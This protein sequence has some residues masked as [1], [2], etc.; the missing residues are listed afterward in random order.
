M[1][2]R[3][4]SPGPVLL[5]AASLPALLAVLA[6]CESMPSPGEELRAQVV[7]VPRSRAELDGGFTRLHAALRAGV[8]RAD[9]EAGRLWLAQCVEPEASALEGLRPRTATLLLPPGLQPAV[10]TVV[11]IDALQGSHAR[12]LRRHGRFVNALGSASAAADPSGWRRYLGNPRPLCRPDGAAEGRWRV[13]LVGAVAAW[14]IDFARAELARH[15]AIADAEL[16][17]GRVALVSC[18]LK[19]ADGSDWTRPSWLTRT[20][21]RPPLRVGD[22]VRIVAGAEEAGRA[23]GPLAR[24]LEVVPGVAPPSDS[25]VV[26][27]R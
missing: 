2:V 1:R 4:V 15:D 17:A 13:Q 18:Q 27:C 8:A 6:G 12:D 22:V 24:V 16:A 20:P 10:G 3:G 7:A 5:A 25:G 23:A 9:A 14:E 26:R 21:D 11:E 19:V